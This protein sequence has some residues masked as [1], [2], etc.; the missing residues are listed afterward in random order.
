[1]PIRILIADDHGVIRAGLRALLSGFPELEVV[2][3]AMDGRDTV[4]KSVE[5]QPN[6]VIMDLSMPEIGRA[7]V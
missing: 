7:H 5:L 1:M 4:T 6:I 2:G 3:E